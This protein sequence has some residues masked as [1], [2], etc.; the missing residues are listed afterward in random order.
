MTIVVSPYGMCLVPQRFTHGNV[1]F[2][3]GPLAQSGEQ[4]RPAITE[5]SV[6]TGKGARQVIEPLESGVRH[7]EITGA[8]IQQFPVRYSTVQVRFMTQPQARYT[9]RFT[10]DIYG[11]Y[12]RLPAGLGQE[13]SKIAGAAPYFDDSTG[14]ASSS[15]THTLKEL[16]SHSLLYDSVISVRFHVAA[17]VA[18]DPDFV[19]R[20]GRNPPAYY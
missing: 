5:T 2:R 4:H 18:S 6:V 8:L 17:E 13:L 19:N 9:Q 7:Q 16:V 1:E 12:F 11:G 3:K 20:H 10:A 14:V 15:P